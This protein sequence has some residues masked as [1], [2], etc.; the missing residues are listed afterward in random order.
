MILLAFKRRQKIIH[1]G[2]GAAKA[3]KLFENKIKMTLNM[4]PSGS[5]E[6]ERAKMIPVNK[7]TSY[8]GWN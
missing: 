4:T 8:G 3:T 5:L 6:L 7:P 1:S 2:G